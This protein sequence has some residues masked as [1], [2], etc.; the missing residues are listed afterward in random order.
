[1]VFVIAV[2]FGV[3]ALFATGGWI[4]SQLD[5]I[6]AQLADIKQSQSDAA[7][8]AADLASDVD[9]LLVLAQGGADLTDIVASL[10]DIQT[11]AR[12]QADAL[13]ATS[14]KFPTT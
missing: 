8:A 2:F 1:M 4:M 7:A 12:A 13:K 6:K 10:T 11:T 9:A 3:F 14:E 5:D